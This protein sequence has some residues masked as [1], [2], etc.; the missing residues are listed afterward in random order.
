MPQFNLFIIQSENRQ[1]CL[2]FVSQACR[3]CEG[4]HNLLTVCCRDLR[5]WNI[6]EEWRENKRSFYLSIKLRG[7]DNIC[8]LNANDADVFDFIQVSRSMEQG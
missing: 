2:Y 5:L 8:L 7:Y 3:Q 1:F 4:L 6:S